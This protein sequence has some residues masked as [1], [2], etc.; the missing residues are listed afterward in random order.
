MKI[1]HYSLGF[2]PYRRGGLT[3]YCL[4][5]MA[6][7]KMQN[8][9]VAMC[10]PGDMGIVKKKKISIKKHACYKI[11][12]SEV[13]N[14]EIKGLLPVPLLEGIADPTVFMQVRDTNIWEE[15]LKEWKPEIIHFHTLMGL[16]IEFVEKANNLGIKTIFTTHD[17]FGI[18]PRTTL[19]CKN[20]TICDGKKTSCCAEC[21]DGAPG[22]RKLAILQSPIYR[23]LKDSIIIKALRKKHWNNSKNNATV[24]EQFDRKIVKQSDDYVELRNYYIALLKKFS[25]IHFNSSNTR[26]V[27]FNAVNEPLNGEVISISHSMIRDNKRKRIQ[28]K[29]IKFSYLGPDTY[30]KGYYLLK[31]VMKQLYD[32]GYRFKLNI[33]FEDSNV[34]FLVSHKPY[35]Y[36]ELESVMDDADC[37][38]VPSLWNET[39][40]FTVLEALSY[41]VPVIVSEKVGAKDLI[42]DKNNGIVVKDNVD[43]LKES[44]RYILEHPEILNQMNNYILANTQIKTMR[45]HACEIEKLYQN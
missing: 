39:F 36:D 35:H 21:C 22:Y 44:I 1:L 12:Q 10:W 24:K 4:D 30:N 33:Y 26:N 17:Y 7:Q 8:H 2:P 6:A 5:L 32:E 3:K 20:G 18:C 28:K 11:E 41:G 27:Y 37:V 45:E 25:I 19:V 34:P 13:E 14:F 43:S 9:D 31:N 16:P 42:K 23:Q 38:A 29:L 40:G 15:F